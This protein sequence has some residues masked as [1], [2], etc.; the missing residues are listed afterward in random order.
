ME[1]SSKASLPQESTGSSVQC[2]E[3]EQ[4]TATAIVSSAGASICAEC[5]R[6][7]YVACTD[8]G[9]LIPR[10]ESLS[11]NDNACCAE[12]FSRPAG[13]TVAA[14][15]DET[16]IESL[17]AEYIALHA[18]EKRLSERMDVVKEQLKNAA[19]ARNRE[20]SS[21]TLRAGDAAVRCSYRASLKCDNESAEALAQLLD[22]EQFSSL[23]ER[24]LSF[25]PVKDC[26]NEFLAGTDQA[27]QDARDALRAAL[28]QTET[29]TLSIVPP[30]K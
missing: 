4:P 9:G 5:I 8:C 6:E 19:A 14:T 25:N 30:R 7:Y 17:I 1:A 24:K 22:E 10:D 29:V 23:F 26:I 28:R 11:R 15:V 27:Q 3:C 21:V 18:E 20:G 12:C 2:A 16:I 13:G